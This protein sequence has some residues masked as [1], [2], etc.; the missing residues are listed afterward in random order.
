MDKNKIFEQVQTVV[1]EVLKIDAAK[2]ELNSLYMKDLGADSLDMIRLII[3][4]EDHFDISLMMDA[5]AE[6]GGLSDKE[7]EQ[8]KSVEGSVDALIAR[9]E[10]ERV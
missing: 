6:E 4:F 8:L 5:A 3:G 9:L 1:A 7:L 2:I 10:L